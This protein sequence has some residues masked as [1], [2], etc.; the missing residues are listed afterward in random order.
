MC[1][2]LKRRWGGDENAGWPSDYSISHH[3]LGVD[4]SD[5]GEVEDLLILVYLVKQKSALQRLC[6]S[7]S[8]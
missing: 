3:S 5:N 6:L 8:S 1:I 4:I 7:G 2:F